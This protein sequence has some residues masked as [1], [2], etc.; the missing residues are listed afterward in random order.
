[1][2]LCSGKV[3]YDLLAA[4]RD[5]NINDVALLRL[6]QLYPFPIRSLP[7]ILKPFKTAEVVWCQEE[8][9]NNGAWTFVDRRL[10]AVL[11]ALDIAAN[12]PR[13]VGRD[14]AASPA[15]GQAS[16]HAAQQAALVQEALK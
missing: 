15:T 6:E 14:E 8:P 12:R 2:V 16:A 1:V 9:M 5:E 13:Y 10:E 4:R 3:Y 7:E 11:S